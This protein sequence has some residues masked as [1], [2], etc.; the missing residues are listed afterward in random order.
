MRKFLHCLIISATVTVSAGCTALGAAGGAY[1]G[2]EAT[3]GS[4]LGTMGG[5]AAGA[6]IGHELGHW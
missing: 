4:T 6:I 1:I 3:H 5:A 2:H